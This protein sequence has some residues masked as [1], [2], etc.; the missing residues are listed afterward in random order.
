MPGLPNRGA[1]P[2]AAPAVRLHAEQARE[3]THV[4]RNACPSP[5]HF[6]PNE[7]RTSHT[8][9]RNTPAGL[10]DQLPRSS[11]SPCVSLDLF[12]CSLRA[13]HVRQFS[14]KS[15][16]TH[17]VEQTKSTPVKHRPSGYITKAG[18]CCFLSREFFFPASALSCPAPKQEIG[19]YH[20]S[21]MLCKPTT[22]SYTVACLPCFD[23]FHVLQPFAA[24]GSNRK[25]TRDPGR[26]VPPTRPATS[27]RCSS[28]RLSNGRTADVFAARLASQDPDS[29]G[30]VFC[31]AVKR[32]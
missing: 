19:P 25:A 29:T 2:V 1:R 23:D 6:V 32:G 11:S 3:P 18:V 9:T 14:R 7:H 30:L 10:H 26:S 16:Q 20:P 17:P 12:R 24:C 22:S 28:A 27:F 4:C 15:L 31:A 21:S 5:S 8:S 13:R